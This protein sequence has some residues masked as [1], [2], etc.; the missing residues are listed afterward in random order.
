VLIAP[1]AIMITFGFKKYFISLIETIIIYPEE[2][3]S[4]INKAYHK[5]ETNLHLKTVVFSWQDFEQGYKIGDDNLNLGIHEFG[6]AIHLNA[7]NNT[8]SSSIIFR[9]EF[10]QLTNYLQN[11]ESVR[12]ELMASKYFRTFAYAAHFEYFEVLLE[13]FIETPMAFKTQFSE[14]YNYIK[15]MLNFKFAGY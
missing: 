15:R 4:N 9:Q 11:N 7:F 12:L 2:Y 5:D 10:E 14:L 1:T 6:H 3:Y 13:N 8:D